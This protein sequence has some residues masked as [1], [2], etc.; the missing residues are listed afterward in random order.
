LAGERIL[1]I[2]DNPECAEFLLTNVL[3]PHGYLAQTAT[4][5][6]ASLRAA[7]EERPDLILLDLD[8]NEETCTEMLHEMQISGGPPVILM[9]HP[10]TEA[11]AL[12]AIRLGARDALIKPFTAEE[13]ARAI[14]RTLH[15]ERLAGER[16]ELVRKLA[17]ANRELE[18]SL[19][20]MRTLYDVGTTVGAGLDLQ[21]VLTATVQAAVSITHAEEAYLL[22]RDQ[23]SDELYLRAAQNLDE[24]HVTGCRVQ[25]DD[26]VAGHVVRT[27]EPVTLSNE[28]DASIKIKTGHLVRS[29]INV[30]LQSQEQVIGVLGV[31]NVVSDQD[32]TQRDVM[33]LSALADH[34]AIAINNAQ[35][36][37]RTAQA[38]GRRVQET[39]ALQAMRKAGEVSG[40]VKRVVCQ[41]LTH[42]IQVTGA[43]EGVVGLWSEHHFHTL[44]LHTMT[45]EQDGMGEEITWM[46][47]EGSP[48]QPEPH[49]EGI[50]RLALDSSEPQRMQNAIL[51]P[52]D[53]SPSSSTYLATPIQQG[54]N[55]LGAIG[56][57][58]NSASLPDCGPH[59]DAFI[60]EELQF[61]NELAASVADRLNHVRLLAEF[62]TTQHKTNLILQ[63]TTEGVY[64]V[65]KDLRITSVNPAME[66]ITGW[67][68]SELV[69]RRYDDVFA[70]E[71][72]GHRLPPEQTLP[73]KAFK[74]IT[75]PSQSPASVTGQSTILH[76]EGRR[77]PVAGTATLLRDASAPAAGVL[78]TM[79]DLTPEV[80]LGQLR[81]EFMA[82]VTHWLRAPLTHISSSAE[83]LLQANLSDDMQR[84]IL[85]MLHTQ[86]VCLDQLTEEMLDILHL[87]ASTTQRHCHPVTLKPI[88]DQV[89]R[90]FQ[91]AVS[92]RS[93]QVTLAPDLPFVIGDESRIELALASLIDNMLVQS[94]PQWPIVISADASDDCVV[95]AVRGTGMAAQA[96]EYVRLFHPPRP[97]YDQSA[98]SDNQKPSPALECQR[99]HRPALSA[100]LLKGEQVLRDRWHATQMGAREWATP[101]MGL[102]IAKKLIRA[103]GGQIWIENQPGTSPQF[104]F[105]LP[106]IEVRDDEQALI[107]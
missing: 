107:D 95:V 41:A 47:H 15:Q 90:N 76:K 83:A 45:R 75:V 28:R 32:F 30:P 40:D 80:E 63:N 61:L 55:T 105:S 26:S 70:P 29:L 100:P 93:F 46:N 106:R 48:S 86:S 10:G 103:Q 97:V 13:M 42:A 64:T 37:T 22:L 96:G 16:D 92:D 66:R 4:C 62:S 8:L 1:I 99:A 98:A 101:E 82:V 58:I 79:R 54:D 78:A 88:I 5:E 24:D 21:D 9:M 3:S 34:A 59:A 77:I 38:L 72:E 23:G 18:C 50:V 36:Y 49:L 102:Y 71:V 52:S 17:A 25:V 65:D 85:D 68:E 43:V 12:R 73:G 6:Q 57:K 104:R 20:E 27:G 44:S 89:V 74:S 33:L 11:E 14:A 67:Q 81:H 19:S 51:H 87:E 35:V 69:G 39:S 91:G 84:E 94:D 56:L 53:K 2:E 7:Q 31:D 60:R